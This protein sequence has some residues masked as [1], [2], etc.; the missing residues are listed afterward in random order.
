MNKSSIGPQGAGT[1][2]ALERLLAAS[3]SLKDLPPDLRAELPQHLSVRRIPAGSPVFRAADSCTGYPVVLS[4]RVRVTRTLDNG[5]ELVLY[6]VEPG[7]SCVMSLGCLL[8]NAPYG[9]QGQCVTDVEIALLSPQMFDRLLSEFPPFRAE[10]FGMFTDR[11]M[12][13]MELVEDVGFKRLEQR[14]AAALLGKGQRVSASHEQL[15]Q[16]LGVSRESVSRQLKH[17]EE[18]GWVRLGRGAVDILDPRA[19]RQIASSGSVTEITE[20]TLRSE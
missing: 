2:V 1:H 10:V 12:R 14:L 13:L 8:G 19:L 18:H 11:L 20:T 15:A 9:A 7:E 4:G 16:Q 5:R 17:F 6:E 3:P